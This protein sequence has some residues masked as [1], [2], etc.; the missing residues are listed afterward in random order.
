MSHPII[1]PRWAQRQVGLPPTWSWSIPHHE[2][3]VKGHRRQTQTPGAHARSVAFTDSV[4][5]SLPRRQARPRRRALLLH[6]CLPPLPRTRS[7]PS[8]LCE[9]ILKRASEQARRERGVRKRRGEGGC[10]CLLPIHITPQAKYMSKV[11]TSQRYTYT[12]LLRPKALIR[13]PNH[14]REDPR[15]RGKKA[16]DDCERPWLTITNTWHVNTGHCGDNLCIDS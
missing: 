6:L 4:K 12:H 1:S 15:K 5:Y 9:C 7:L 13:S 16:A 10:R 11:L 3:H 8:I 14:N 2:P